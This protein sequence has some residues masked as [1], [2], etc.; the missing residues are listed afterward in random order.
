MAQSATEPF[1]SCIL[2]FC[3]E[4]SSLVTPTHPWGW[5]HRIWYLYEKAGAP[6]LHFS[7]RCPLN[8]DFSLLL[9]SCPCI[10]QPDC[11]M[12][13]PIVF[14]QS[15]LRWELH[16]AEA[17]ASARQHLDIRHECIS[18]DVCIGES[19]SRGWLTSSTVSGTW[20]KTFSAARFLVCASFLRKGHDVLH[21]EGD[22]AMIVGEEALEQ[23]VRDSLGLPGSQIA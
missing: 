1:A 12:A 22:E 16:A 2:L 10:Q 11:S 4:Q 5:I 7:P 20:M 8:S 19:H 3:S 21:R 6:G 9:S 23:L 13:L 15:Q 14:G 17:Q 18:M